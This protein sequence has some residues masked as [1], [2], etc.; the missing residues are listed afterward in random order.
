MHAFI[1]SSNS[2]L[3]MIKVI[4]FFNIDKTYQWLIG[5]TTLNFEKL[6][7]WLKGNNI[8]NIDKFYQ[9]LLG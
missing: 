5:K 4:K 1:T 3:W 9:L 8:L 7:Q 2:H 6:Y